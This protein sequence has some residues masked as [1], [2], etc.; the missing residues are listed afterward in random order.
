MFTCSLDY[1]VV[2]E[3]YDLVKQVMYP[4]TSPIPYACSLW[5]RSGYSRLTLEKGRRILQ[6][7]KTGVRATMYCGSCRRAAVVR[8]F[9]NVQ[10]QQQLFRRKRDSLSPCAHRFWYHQT[11]MQHTMFRFASGIDILVNVIGGI[12]AVLGLLLR[13]HL[14]T[15]AGSPLCLYLTVAKALERTPPTRDTP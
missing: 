9:N 15:F 1:C 4:D 8:L 12:R 6:N 13:P 3:M 14:K 10:Q 11:L 2:G 5:G 7:S